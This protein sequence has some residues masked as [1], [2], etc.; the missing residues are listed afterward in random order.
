MLKSLQHKHR[1][2]TEDHKMNGSSLIFFNRILQKNTLKKKERKKDK[3]MLTLV[4]KMFSFK[5]VLKK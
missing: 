4:K 1:K 2:G 5:R 3:D